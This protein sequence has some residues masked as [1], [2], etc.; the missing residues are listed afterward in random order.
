MPANN[1]L[2]NEATEGRIGIFKNIFLG[3]RLLV[4]GFEHRQL[5]V[6]WAVLT[7]NL[8]VVTRMAEAEK[9]RR[10][11]QEHQEASASIRAA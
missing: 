5:A 8:W 1:A 10:E 4:K 3:G 6:G 7:H 2:S 9:K 11:H